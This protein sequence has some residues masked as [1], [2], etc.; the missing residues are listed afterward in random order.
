MR[1]MVEGQP[2]AVRPVELPLHHQ[3][4]RAGG[5]P[6]RSGEVLGKANPF[7]YAMERP[8]VPLPL[9]PLRLSWLS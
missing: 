8:V 5:P 2:Q 6:P 1:S 9:T 4:K 7:A 3:P